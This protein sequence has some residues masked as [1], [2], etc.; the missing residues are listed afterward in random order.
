M[1]VSLDS[2]GSTMGDHVVEG[3]KNPTTET[4]NEQ[5]KREKNVDVDRSAIGARERTANTGQDP[6]AHNMIFYGATMI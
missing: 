6:L 3:R 2:R 1:Y 5:V 4:V